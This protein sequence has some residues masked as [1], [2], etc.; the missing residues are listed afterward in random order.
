MTTPQWIVVP[1]LA[2]G[3]TWADSGSLTGITLTYSKGR[4]ECPGLTPKAKAL[5]QSLVRYVDGR[6]PKWPDLDLDFDSLPPFT[7]RVLR[8]LFEGVGHGRVVSYGRL[9]RM[10]GSPK[11]ARAVGQALA[12]NPWPL[13]VPCHR[14]LGSD[15]SLTGFTNPS[16]VDL[17]RDLLEMEG[18]RPGHV[19][20]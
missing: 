17:K 5:R 10:A 19:P 14:V 20:V 1:P 18:V 13:V 16:G 4:K 2:L 12:R 3:L 6:E 7:G 15:G 9:A 11:A 8:A